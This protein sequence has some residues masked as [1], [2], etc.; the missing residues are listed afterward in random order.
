MVSSRLALLSAAAGAVAGMLVALA[1]G[2]GSRSADD[3]G[4]DPSDRVAGAVQLAT[5]STST[6]TT[7]STSTTTTVPVQFESLRGVVEA[8]TPEELALQLVVTGAVGTDMEVPI[9]QNGGSL[10]LGGL[11]VSDT[12]EN[13]GGP[14]PEDA[15]AAIARLATAAADGCDIGPLV[16]TDAEAGS[17]LRVP[18]TP[19][20]APEVFEAAYGGGDDREA[21]H[22]L[23]SDTLLLATELRGLG[24]HVNLGIVAD[25]DA[26]PGFYMARTGRTFGRDPSVV[27]VMVGEMVAAHCHVGVAAALKHFPNQGSTPEDPHSSLSRSVGTIDDWRSRGAVPYLDHLDAPVVLAGHI[28]YEDVDAGLP[29][30]LSRAIITGLLREELGY[31]GVIITD[32]LL[33]MNG[34]HAGSTLAVER[35]VAAIEAG[36]DLT[37]WIGPDHIGEIVAALAAR[38]RA[39]AIFREQVLGSVGRI[40][41]LKARFG[42]VDGLEATD[43]DL[44]PV[45]DAD[46]FSTP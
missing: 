29:A 23:G 35:A 16:V 6:T 2:A 20:A 12:A 14:R 10:C 44:C 19:V 37:L 25:V 18:V 36:A 8:M 26:D 15:R 34:A 24:V 33:V 17:V 9:Q 22:R 39:D 28:V 5:P 41:R 46:P 13:F 27:S 4:S 3:P 38:I 21:L 32:E 30:S 7:T 45:G 40:L 31:G 43:F 11:F 42:L 1:L